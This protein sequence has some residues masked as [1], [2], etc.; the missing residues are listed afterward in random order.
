MVQLYPAARY[1]AD[2]AEHGSTV[3]VFNIQH[4]EGDEDAHFLSL[5]SCEKML[6]LGTDSM[7]VA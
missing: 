7:K 6:P 5:G 3:A 2:V 4:S 1:A